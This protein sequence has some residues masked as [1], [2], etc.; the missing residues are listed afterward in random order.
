MR[1]VTVIGPLVRNRK[2]FLDEAGVVT[3]V[4]PFWPPHGRKIDASTCRLGPLIV[5]LAHNM[6]TE[7]TARLLDLISY[8]S[9]HRRSVPRR[10]LF[11]HIKGYR[12]KLERGVKAE[13][14][15]KEFMRDQADLK[16]WGIEI[17]REKL[18][19]DESA[20]QFGYR[21]DDNH[22]Y[23]P[24]ILEDGDEARSYPP[25]EGLKAISVTGEDLRVLDR[26]TRRLAEREELPLS[27]SA[28]S[29]RRKFNFDVT[30]SPETIETILSTPTKGSVSKN[31]N[32]LQKGI[33]D[34]QAVELEYHTI[35]RDDVKQR[36]IEPYGLFLNWGK[37][38]CAA[39]PAEKEK[40][41]V[42]RVDRMKNT[43][44]LKGQGFSAPAEFRIADYS[45]RP[46]WV[47]SSDQGTDVNVRFS[48]PQSRWV[49]ALNLGRIVEPVDENGGALIC[50]DVKKKDPFLRWLLT[51]RDNAVIES[52]PEFVTDLTELKRRVLALY[53]AGDDG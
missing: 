41:Q 8:L 3:I 27:R 34:E 40:T 9:A 39:R 31:L 22:L 35:E 14:V 24:Y 15:R 21:L 48:F 49:Q 32:V 47:L 13:S 10:E 52:P 1:V 17:T 18:T 30:L 50:F 4:S 19:H 25:Y 12:E 26:A 53:S 16:S 11:E 29:L 7:K 43:R 51:Y 23:L 33:A 36:V 37:W 20:D 45:G 42:F 28:K 44:V 46:P 38:Y 2:D 6:S 5:A